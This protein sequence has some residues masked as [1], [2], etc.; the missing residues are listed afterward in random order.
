METKKII[1]GILIAIGAIMMMIGG[2]G[3]I[4]GGG[5]FLGESMG[6]FGSFVPLILGIVFFTS[7]IG[8]FKTV[9]GGGSGGA[10]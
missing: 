7:G 4:G 3:L 8:L 1:G 2:M 9:G 6:V 5:Q 10:A